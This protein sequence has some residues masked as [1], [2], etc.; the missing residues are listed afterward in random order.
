MQS[1][2]KR[3][4]RGGERVVKYLLKLKE[5]NLGLTTHAKKRRKPTLDKV[6]AK[7]RG[8]CM[9]GHAKSRPG[10]SGQEKRKKK[11][12]RNGINSAARPAVARGNFELGVEHRKGLSEREGKK[13]TKKTL[14]RTGEKRK[15]APTGLK[16]YK[17]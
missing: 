15:E 8:G 2:G 12:E 10:C 1:V 5:Y 4:L 3:V 6:T 7:C 16:V 13:G 11:M 9:G 17:K 14:Q